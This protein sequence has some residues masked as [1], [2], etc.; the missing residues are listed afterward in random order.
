MLKLSKTQLSQLASNL[1]A[2]RGDKSAQSLATS[3]IIAYSCNTYG[4]KTTAIYWHDGKIYR[5]I[6]L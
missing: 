3:N 4:Y 2:A 1:N 5:T 6:D